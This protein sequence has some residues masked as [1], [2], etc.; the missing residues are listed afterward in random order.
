MNILIVGATGQLGFTIVRKLSEQKTAHSIF[1]GHRR[2]SNTK[3][4]ERLRN[5]N[6]R[7][8]DLLDSKTFETGLRDID[9]IVTTATTATPSQKGDHL[10]KTD[11]N[12]TMKLIDA[13]RSAG[14]KH[15][16]YVSALPFPKLEN[17]VPLSR[18][19]RR[20]ESHL[21][22]SGLPYTIIQPTAFME[23]YFPFFGTTVPL[24]GAEVNTVD[25]PFKF[26]ND[27]FAGI[28]NDI[29]QKE[30]FNVIGKGDRKNAFISVENVADFCIAA[31]SN[32]KAIN[33]I[34]E[35]GGP[36]GLSPLDIKKIF[37]RLYGKP[38]KIKSTPPFVIRLMSKIL[39]LVNPAAGNIMALNYAV[40]NNDALPR[41]MKK[42]AE[43]FDIKL[44]HPEEFLSHKF[45]LPS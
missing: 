33:R 14:I 30:T 18:A 29:E 2:T 28:K 13:A 1:A 19:K 8:V 25:R 16:I 41:D 44:I 4:L 6:F 31:I 22:R 3:P 27:F 10:E 32:P 26:S 17:T 43:E 37:E 38:L 5:V 24:R 7:L 11:E 20:V 12:G 39:A 9:I 15:F 42:T 40:A 21:K 34:I 35:I 45:A 23:V 36:E